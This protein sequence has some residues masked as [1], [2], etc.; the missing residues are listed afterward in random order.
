MADIGRQSKGFEARERGQ[1]RACCESTRPRPAG[2]FDM[3]MD[4]NP[5]E[6]RPDSNPRSNWSRSELASS[7]PEKLLLKASTPAL[8]NSVGPIQAK[9]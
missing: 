9:I 6:A 4:A 8:E 7:L 5:Y 3:A 1:V 2:V